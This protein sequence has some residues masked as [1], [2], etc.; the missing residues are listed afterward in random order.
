MILTSIFPFPWAPRELTLGRLPQKCRKS[1]ACTALLKG[2]QRSRWDERG[3][4]REKSVSVAPNSSGHPWIRKTTGH[5][6]L[7]LRQSSEIQG[8][9]TSLLVISS[10]KYFRGHLKTVTIFASSPWL[11]PAWLGIS[12]LSSPSHLGGFLPAVSTAPPQVCSRSASPVQVSRLAQRDSGEH[13]DHLGFSPGQL[14]CLMVFLKAHSFS[15][16]QW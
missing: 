3:W 14:A 4:G 9:L 10:A 16:M 2:G 13:C 7:H 5:V 12:F 15:E 1:Q 11:L 6:I 8:N